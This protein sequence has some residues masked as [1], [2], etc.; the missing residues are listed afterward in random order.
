V[1]HKEYLVSHRESNSVFISHL[2]F[3]W[4]RHAKLHNQTFNV[5]RTEENCRIRELAEIVGEIV[6][7]ARARRNSTMPIATLGSPPKI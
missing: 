3:K 5:G 6:P 7:V 2:F 1:W 4:T